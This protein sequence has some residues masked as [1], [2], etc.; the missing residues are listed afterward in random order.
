MESRFFIRIALATGCVALAIPAILAAQRQNT[1]YPHF[2]LIDLGTLGGANSF[3][4]T[5]ATGLINRQGT[6]VAEADTTIPDPYAP[7]CFQT[8]FGE[9]VV[10]HALQW[11]NGKVTDLGALPGVNSS[12]PDWINDYGAVSGFSENGM[13]DPLTGFPEVIAVEWS[14]GQVINLGTLGGNASYAAAI[15]D[16][17]Q[18]AGYALNTV[19]D[20]YSNLLNASNFG[21]FFFGVATAVHG[22]VWDGKNGIQDLG[23]LGGPD[24]SAFFINESGQVAGDSFINSNPNPNATQPCIANVPTQDPFFWENGVI[25]DMGSLGGDCGWPNG[26]NNAGEVIG[27]STPAGDGLT[28]PFLWTKQTGMQALSVTSS[29]TTGGEAYAI[30]DAGQVVGYGQNPTYAF[31]LLWENGTV[32]R[33]GNLSGANCTIAFA[34]NSHGQ[35]AGFS[36]PGSTTGCVGRAVFWQPGGPPADLNLLVQP[37]SPLQLYEADFINDRGEIAGIGSL[38]NGD[39]HAFL[40]I[41]CDDAHPGLDGC[42][43]STVDASAVQTAAARPTQR[44]SSDRVPSSL[45]WRRNNRFHFP[46]TGPQN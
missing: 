17:G 38:A 3:V 15:N 5:P 11:K 23:T 28:L 19:S 7:N 1:Q 21:L 44:E 22:A 9:C 18:I 33:L 40:A 36:G 12:Y 25:T 16:R 30:N 2:K 41:P 13:M 42:D 8:Y 46:L 34:I 32:R 6:V 45:L 14:D 26:M 43:Y 37:N 24:S 10:N 20:S 29:G 31:A 35:V 27:D 39:N 4:G